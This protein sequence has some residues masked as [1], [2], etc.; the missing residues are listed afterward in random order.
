MKKLLATD[1]DG[2]LINNNRISD[3]NKQAINNLKNNNHILVVSTG[4]P[5]NGITF[6]K[7]E[8]NVVADYYVLLNGALI[9][10]KEGKTVK[11]EVI[12]YNDIVSILKNFQ[13]EN[14]AIS[15]ETGY[16]TYV[17]T[18]WDNLPYADKTNLNSI[19]ELKDKE[20]SL[21]S[22]YC[23]DI[24]K[25]VIEEMK[26]EINKK[27]GDKIIAYRNDV[28]IDIVPVGCSK[29][30]GVEYVAKV[31]NL[32]KKSIYTIGDS[33]NDLTMFNITDNS[34]TFNNVE[35]ELK[36][37]VNNLVDSVAECIIEYIL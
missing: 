22:M 2:T 15:V 32:D 20:I 14:M 7:E 9:I 25:V 3:N 8:D 10:D 18:K 19:E 13:K 30:H 36:K 1:L 27:Y 31:E 37:Y 16:T 29:G 21:I 34:F 33:W 28:Y 6:L 23:K 4:R 12:K 5:Y 11:H 17:L 24:D 35:E 26:N